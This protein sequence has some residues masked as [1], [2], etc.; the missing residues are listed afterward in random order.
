MYVA[1]LERAGV[2]VTTLPP[3]EDF[4]DS[5][6]V[7]DVALC[8]HGLAIVLRPGDPSRFGEAATIRPG[9]RAAGLRVVELPEGSID[10]G[11]ILVTDDEVFVGLSKRT[12]TAG[13]A[14]LAAALEEL[15]MKVR[16]VETP[17]D[18]LHFKS[19]C[20]LLDSSTIFATAR[21]AET[22]CFAGYDV[23]EA[24]QGEE[25]AANLVRVND[26]VCVADGYPATV[27][28]LGARGYNVETVAV[29]QAA[30]IDGGLSCLSLR[31]TPI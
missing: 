20:G 9:L 26:T 7:E 14:G 29:G 19:D 27:D 8:V 2:S 24:P 15:G 3:L 16:K 22:G 4:P 13:L 11:D 21:L 30:L 12:N 28:L 18:I 5:V 6:F 31:F 10:G 1:A 17:A 23:V 25:A